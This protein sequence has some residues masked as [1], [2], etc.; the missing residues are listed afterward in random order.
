[1][2]VRAG[3]ELSAF[4]TLDAM[5]SVIHKEVNA[6]ICAGIHDGMSAVER[7]G[8]LLGPPRPNHPWLRV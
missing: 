4:S 1:M 8:L 7:A 3:L 2:A 6:S 5:A